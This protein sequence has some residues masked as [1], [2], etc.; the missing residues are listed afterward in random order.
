MVTEKK[1]CNLSTKISSS[2]KGIFVFKKTWIFAQITHENKAFSPKSIK[3]YLNLKRVSF[4]WMPKFASLKA[5]GQRR[6]IIWILDFLKMYTIYTKQ[7][8]IW[9]LKLF[10]YVLVHL[11]LP[12]IV[13]KR[14]PYLLISKIHIELT[15][16]QSF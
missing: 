4:C 5:W 10:V 16:N 14:S 3:D 8:K 11:E 6:I 12:I 13:G 1:N 2:S 7:G 9:F 15:K